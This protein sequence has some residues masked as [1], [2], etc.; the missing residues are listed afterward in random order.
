MRREQRRQIELEVAGGV[1]AAARS[2]HGRVGE[3]SLGVKQR[4]EIERERSVVW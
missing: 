3:A 1:A 4:L 2:R